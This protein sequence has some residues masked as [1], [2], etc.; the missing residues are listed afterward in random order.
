MGAFFV[1]N[2][3]KW[4]CSDAKSHYMANGE[5]RNQDMET[6]HKGQAFQVADLDR[7]MVAMAP[8]WDWAWDTGHRDIPKCPWNNGVVMGKKGRM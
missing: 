6:S 1:K 7:G 2:V 5:Y 4:T 8:F 3:P